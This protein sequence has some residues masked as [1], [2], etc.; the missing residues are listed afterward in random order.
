MSRAAE[1]LRV[2][3]PALSQSL[4]ELER[5]LGVPLFEKVGRTQRLTAAGE[6][7]AAFARSTLARG[8]DLVLRLGAR[9][10]GEAG[11]LR[12]GMIESVSL[13]VLPR[14]ASRL[15]RASP[16]VELR[17]S[18][19][20]SSVLADEL[21][22]FELDVAFVVGPLS[23]DRL[24]G[25]TLAREPMYVYAARGSGAQAKPGEA[26][27]AMYP[28]ESRTRAIVEGGLGRIG[29]S[30]RVMVES[31]NPR[32]LRQVVASG[33]CWSVLPAGVAE[34]GQSPLERWRRTPVV[35]REVVAAR[36][37]DAPPDGRV[38]RFLELM[39]EAY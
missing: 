32:V 27:W 33:L 15:R 18:V 8:E 29:T 35:Y 19:G 20:S 12:V 14:V 34:T 36:R 7:V 5:R 2:S 16:A 17:L 25:E 23:S 38:D 10:R 37:V 30:A 9:L 39:G 3:Q 28:P 21:E 1:R 22:R 4:H 6:E 13:A 11:L 26:Q 31:G 24:V